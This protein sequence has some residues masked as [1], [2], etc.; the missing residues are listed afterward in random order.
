MIQAVLL[1]F[2]GTLVRRDILDIICGIV[3][4][5]A[6]SEQINREFH[7]GTRPGLGALVERINFLKGVSQEQIDA[8]LQ[9]E[10]YLM[11][12]ARELLSY[13]NSHRIVTILNSGNIKPVLLA[14]Q[15]ILGIT[16]VV[17]SEPLMKGNVIQ[18]IS[19]AQF[20]GP[21]FKLEGARQILSRLDIASSDTVAIGDSPADRLAFEYAGVSIAINP[22]GGV[23]AASDYVIQDDL[24]K[25]IDIIEQHRKGP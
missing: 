10:A 19:E 21:N 16:Y 25:A 5:E 4:K 3:G 9:E 20:S 1:D 14:Y 7:A 12:G 24:A 6:A 22:R 8:K 17:G 13:L 23:E 15:K 2:D 11:P 18:G